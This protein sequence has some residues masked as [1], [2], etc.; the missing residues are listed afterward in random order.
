MVKNGEILQFGFS[1]HHKNNS[2]FFEQTVQSKKLLDEY[3]DQINVS[4]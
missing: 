2:P 4:K 1:I 3:E